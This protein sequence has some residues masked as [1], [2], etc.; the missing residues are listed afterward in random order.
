M[1]H[2]R[3]VQR[4]SGKFVAQAKSGFFWHDLFCGPVSDLPD[5]FD[6]VEAAEKRIRELH[7]RSPG[8]IKWHV[9]KEF[10]LP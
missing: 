7:D 4:P 6:T 5:E 8:L 1:R 2:Y 9:V 3:I 10:T